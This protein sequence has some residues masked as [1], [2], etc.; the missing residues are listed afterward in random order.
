MEEVD[1]KSGTLWSSKQ[2]DLQ[3]VS[4]AVC[5]FPIG[6]KAV[7]VDVN[8]DDDNNHNHG[9]APSDRGKLQHVVCYVAV[10]DFHESHVHVD[11]FQP[12]PRE[13][14]QQEVVEKPSS[15]NAKPHG[16]C[17]ERQPRVHQEHQVEQQQSE[18]QVD[19]DF[20]RYV[21]A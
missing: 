9:D 8:C 17:V 16:V 21:F 5:I 18:A 2:E 12:H 13:G 19:Q 10:E 20:G 15:G 14:R 4:C 6:H 3:F 7:V 11:A 1:Y